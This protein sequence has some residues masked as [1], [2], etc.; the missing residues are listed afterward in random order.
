MKLLKIFLFVCFTLAGWTAINGWMSFKDYNL[1]KDGKWQSGKTKL[2]KG[3][4][5]GWAMMLSN[6]ALAGGKLNINAW[7]GYQEITL[8]KSIGA[9]SI[10]FSYRPAW[11][12]FS[13][14]INKTDSGNTAIMFYPDGEQKLCFYVANAAGKF[15]SKQSVVI[16]VI[17][18]KR[19]AEAR[20]DLAKD[21]MR[22]YIN[23]VF[24]A[25]F[26]FVS[27]QTVNPGFKGS[28]EYKGLYIDDIQIT[29]GDAKPVLTEQFNYPFRVYSVTVWYLV[30]WMLVLVFCLYRKLLN[31]FVV[32]IC[33]LSGMTVAGAFA[34]YYYIGCSKYLS[35][36]EDIN[37]NGIKSL[38]ETGP[39]VN[40]RIAREF[41]VNNI[42]GRKPVIVVMGASQ[43][44]GAGASSSGTTFTAV[45]QDSLRNTL[46]D[47]NITVINVGVSDIDPE[48]MCGDYINRWSLYQPQLVII[49]ASNNGV[50][51]NLLKEKLQVLVTYNRQHKIS[52]LF[53]EGPAEDANRL[54]EKDMA[55]R[56]IA[57]TN[58]ITS[59]EMQ[60]V[61]QQYKDSGYLWWDAVHL[62]D[63][64]H[65]IF[66]K[67]ILPYVL[68]EMK[69]SV[70][71]DTTAKTAFAL[72]A[73]KK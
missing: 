61:M 44:W 32:Y 62:S 28:S 18:V 4:W 33:F 47:S 7:H 57:G 27:P 72:P 26:P 65:Y 50:D 30:V 73:A 56:T 49:N 69:P 35:D 54:F 31:A 20:I 70:R 10:R 29:D 11:V 59:V 16:P 60:S 38:I 41:P 24:A 34:C 45:L 13:F 37:W 12:P 6:A 21:S 55:L 67:R 46:R 15:L 58:G 25:A 71:L 40:E 9:K 5:G 1:Y 14:I 48:T 52:T 42:A 8:K 63:Y 39:M 53:I 36:A 22:I 68:D 64:G 23:H 43:T 3:V 66:A 17:P 51:T 2:E 19:K